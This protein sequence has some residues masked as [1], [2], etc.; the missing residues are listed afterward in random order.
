MMAREARD[1]LA[2]GEARRAVR[3]ALR[4]RV[5]VP[6][7]APQAG[8]VVRRSVEPGASV[9]EA[10][11]VVAIVPWAGLVFEAHLPQDQRGRV[12]VGQRAM[13][14]EEAQAPRAATVERILPAADAADQSTLVW[15]RPSSLDPAPQ[16]DH[17]GT[18]A[19][20]IGAARVATA[21][22]DSAVIEDDVSGE[23]RV[24]V[25][26]TSRHAHWTTVTLGPGEGGWHAVR[27][28]ALKA[29]TMVVVEG[30]R[31]LPDGSRVQWTP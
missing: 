29:G 6:I 16:L 2:R 15:L 17:F 8:I 11:E 30:Q 19:I 18:A 28:P 25:V 3:L 10:A 31:G 20:T 22:P 4:D 24:A 9:A 7:S 14:R 27:A 13:I 1:S 26:D 21:V 5:T 23:K 12:R